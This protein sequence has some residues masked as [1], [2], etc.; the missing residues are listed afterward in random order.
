MVD[1][2]NILHAAT[3]TGIVVITQVQP[4]SVIFTLPADALQAVH[5]AMESGR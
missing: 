2:G 3:A 1:P 4:I 5:K